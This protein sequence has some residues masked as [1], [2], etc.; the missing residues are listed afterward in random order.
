V[1]IA[2]RHK[3]DCLVHK[4][5]Y[6]KIM[7]LIRAAAKASLEV[8]RL[9][10]G[11]RGSCCNI[12]SA[13]AGAAAARLNSIKQR[14]LSE[15]R[16]F[17]SSSTPNNSNDKN[18]N[19]PIVSF[20]KRAGTTKRIGNDFPVAPHTIADPTPLF[21]PFEFPHIDPPPYYST[22]RLP[23]SHQDVGVSIATPE[24]I[25]KMRVSC[26]LAREMLEFACSLAK[27]GVTG[28]QIDRQVHDAILAANAYPSPL[29]YHGFP[30]SLC[31]SVNEVICHGI[32]DSRE[33][34][35]GDIVSFDVSNYIEGCHG[36]NC[37]TVAVGDNVD[38]GGLLLIKAAKEA[39]DAGVSV[40]KPGACLTEIGAAIH[41]VADKYSFS[42]VKQ[43]CG[44]GVG[45]V[46]HT[47][48]FVKHFR[49]RDYMRL[50]PGMIFTIEPMICEGQQKCATWKD[51]WT[52]VSVDG[53]RSAQFEHC[54]LVTDTGVEIL[55]SL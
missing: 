9:K 50:E 4:P 41:E 7:F 25:E 29:N 39:L 47:G 17:Y 19:R 24:Q 1:R 43:Y 51:D 46:F 2:V 12:S 6:K 40:C 26:K 34:R 35:D 32:P 44:H 48:P 11:I 42:S 28:E 10:Q 54:V 49:N 37:A 31:C 13:A 3:N 38:D 52:V 30:K 18:S 8:S 27:P 22:G 55:T 20:S 15:S 53:G 33:L 21:Q 14:Q 45:E 23:M 5:T 16:R 36:D